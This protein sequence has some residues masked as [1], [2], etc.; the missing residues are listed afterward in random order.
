[1]SDSFL[2]SA[3]VD[4]SFSFGIMEPAKLCLQEDDVMCSLERV[5]VQVS[6]CQRKMATPLTIDSHPMLRRLMMGRILSTHRP[7]LCTLQCIDRIHHM[8]RRSSARALR[9]SWIAFL[10]TQMS[11]RL[12]TGR[13]GLQHLLILLIGQPL[14]WKCLGS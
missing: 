7:I 13:D 2:N 9:P 3:L 10:A 6:F 12:H 4:R 5:C 1:M 14:L 11:T 8:G